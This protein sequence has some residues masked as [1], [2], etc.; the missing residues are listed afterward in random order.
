[1]EMHQSLFGWHKEVWKV[2][3]IVFAFRFRAC[4]LV[5]FGS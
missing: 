4:D 3:I 2:Y 1:M 5:A